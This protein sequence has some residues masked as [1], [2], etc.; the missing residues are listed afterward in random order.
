VRLQPGENG[1]GD[2]VFEQNQQRHAV[3]RKELVF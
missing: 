2:F 1:S 3:R